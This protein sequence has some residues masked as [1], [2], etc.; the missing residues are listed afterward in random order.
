MP[1]GILYISS[2]SNEADNRGVSLN[3]VIADFCKVLQHH[4]RGR[5]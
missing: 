1:R 5:N 2:K 3:Y 4:G